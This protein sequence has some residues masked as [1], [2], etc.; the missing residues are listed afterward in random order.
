VTPELEPTPKGKALIAC[1]DALSASR[2]TSADLTAALELR[3]SQ[4]QRG[5]VE[6]IEFMREI[7]A[8]TREIVAAVRAQKH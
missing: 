1:L 8:Y 6:A 3:L 7:E 5:E 2:L 4:V